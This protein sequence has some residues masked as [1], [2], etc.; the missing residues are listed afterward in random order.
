MMKSFE[1][2]PLLL[3]YRKAFGRDDF[4]V[5]KCNEEAVRWIDRDPNWPYFAL[6]ICGETGSGKTHLASIFSDYH[7]DARFLDEDFI[8][9]DYAHKVVL[10]N[11]DKLRDEKALFHLYNMIHDTGRYLLMTATNEPVFKLR[12][13]VTRMNTVPRTM[14]CMPDQDVISMLLIKLFLDKHIHLQPNV[15]EYTL[16]RLPMSFSLAQKLVDKADSM[17]L[18]QGRAV[19][20]PLMKA[21]LDAVFDDMFK[22]NYDDQKAQLH[23]FDFK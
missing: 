18:G 1:Q 3:S 12:D 11:V 10:E 8:L 17:S 16:K 2:L 15:L 5:A 13:L 6:L 4:I 9:P 7:I 21:A 14:I 19:T 23:L 22:K 20:I